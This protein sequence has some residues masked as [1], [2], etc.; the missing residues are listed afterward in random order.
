VS[1][2]VDVNSNMI[3]LL[4][5][6]FVKSVL[7][8]SGF[9]SQYVYS[10]DSVTL[11]KEFL[12][13]IKKVSKRLKNSGYHMSYFDLY[14]ERLN[15]TNIQGN[16]FIDNIIPSLEALF[17]LYGSFEITNFNLNIF[18][19]EK[20]KEYKL[21]IDLYSIY[22][23]YTNS[24]SVIEKRDRESA[25][26]SG[27]LDPNELVN[28]ITNILIE[29]KGWTVESITM[30]AKDINPTISEDGITDLF[31][32]HYNKT[33]DLGGFR[34]NNENEHGSCNFEFSIKIG[35]G[36][37]KTKY[38]SIRH[39]Q[40]FSAN[41]EELLNRLFDV[42]MIMSVFNND[43][44]LEAHI[45]D[46]AKELDGVSLPSYDILPHL[47]SKYKGLMNVIE[48]PNSY[49]VTFSVEEFYNAKF[50]PKFMQLIEFK[51]GLKNAFDDLKDITK[52]AAIGS[53][54]GDKATL[55]FNL[56]L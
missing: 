24:Y 8:V 31:L 5:L 35:Y 47:N 56:F 17:T 20:M 18:D 4:D 45:S 14:N 54:R 7:P 10:A 23:D 33:T 12:E 9:P 43:C 53:V 40:N 36:Y 55:T 19:D 52:E 3:D 46:L 13:A 38:G 41:K 26:D 27:Q 1:S 44:D 15:K 42:A 51:N 11:N 49:V 48:K 21:I 30:A 6:D 32:Y 50:I 16:G 2:E 29:D 39:K 37:H 34:F 25:G 22:E 28:Y